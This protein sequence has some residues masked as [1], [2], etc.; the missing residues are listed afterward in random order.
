M[1][2]TLAVA[3]GPKECETVQDEEIPPSP[4]TARTYNASKVRLSA[5]LSKEP[6]VELAM[7]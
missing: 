5:T 3:A 7:L 1:R 4:L 6:E 2:R